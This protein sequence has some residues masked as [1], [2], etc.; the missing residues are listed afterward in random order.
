[1]FAV[2]TLVPGVHVKEHLFASWAYLSVLFDFHGLP[3]VV[4][5]LAGLVLAVRRRSPADVWMLTWLVPIVEFGLDGSLD[6]WALGT[7]FD[8][9]QIMYPYGI[10]WHALILPLA[11]FAALAAATG[12][13]LMERGSAGD[14]LVRLR[15]PAC[16]LAIVGGLGAAVFNQPLV[17]ATKGRF[18]FTGAY[19]T[20]PDLQAMYWLKANTSPDALVLNY[21][22][23]ESHWAPIVAE[24]NAVYFRPQLFFIGDDPAQRQWADLLPAYLDPAAPGSAD[25]MRDYGVDY[26]LVPQIVTR[27][28]LFPEMLRWRQPDLPLLQSS[29]DEV[30]YLELVV[31]FA[32][33]RVYRVVEE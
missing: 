28:E 6:R 8:P 18:T 4:P 32:G 1:V 31:D 22:D 19:S 30:E 13:R 14:L 25:L 15:A 20:P 9:F 2:L 33:A 26:V 29:F 5:A 21:P 16:G 3:I 23:Y 27:P 17:E 24:R 12:V 7:G 11:Y 10:L